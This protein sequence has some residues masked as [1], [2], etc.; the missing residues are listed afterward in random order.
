MKSLE[1]SSPCC[2]SG[3]DSPKLARGLCYIHYYKAKREGRI[4]EYAREFAIVGG[5]CTVPDCGGPNFGRGLC[6]KHYRA[7][8][9]A[10]AGKCTHLGCVRTGYGRGL[11]QSHYN[12]Q[13][14]S[15]PTNVCAWTDCEVVVRTAKYCGSHHGPAKRMGL[16]PNTKKCLRVK[17]DVIGGPRGLCERH[18]AEARRQGKFTDRKCLA[19]G[20]DGTPAGRG[21]C[22][23]HLSRLKNH[24]DYRIVA[25]KAAPG[26]GMTD[27]WGYRLIVKPGHPNARQS[28]HIAEHRWAM[29]EH[30]GRPLRPKENVHHK[31]GIRDDNRLENLELWSTSQ[32]YG[33]RVED[34]IAWAV[35]FLAQ[36]APHRLSV[37]VSE[38]A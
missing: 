28:G 24:G 16:L 6:R 27:R 10:E 33:Q 12:K 20:C 8:R 9:K 19:E 21:L 34:K 26:E 15:E 13:R 30:L 22:G 18:Y 23:K 4:G 35:E 36:Y 14:A 17:C 25:N 29:A 1:Y 7:K 38:V 11:C 2:V 31:N 3:C 5:K 37:T 32:P